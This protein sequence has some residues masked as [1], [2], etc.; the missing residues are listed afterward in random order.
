MHAPPAYDPFSVSAFVD[1]SMRRFLAPAEPA[2][3]RLLSLDR[4]RQ[5]FAAARLSAGGDPLASL[6]SVLGITYR[7]EPAELERIPRSGPVLV[8]ANHPFGMLEGAIL[9]HRPAAQNTSRCSSRRWARSGICLGCAA[10][11]LPDSRQ[12]SPRMR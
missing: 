10:R 11:M 12:N 7:V 5:V 3:D 4:L 6:F 9:A 8:V 1:E 2:L